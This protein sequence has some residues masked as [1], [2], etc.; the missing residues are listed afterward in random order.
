MKHV[1]DGTSNTM[2]VGEAFHDFEAVEQSGGRPESGLGNR[3][4]HWY[5]GSDDIDTG[6]GSDP[7]KDSDQELAFPSTCRT[8][9]PIS[10]RR[11]QDLPNVRSCSFPLAAFTLAA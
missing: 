8:S 2:F 5:F 11:S 1:I 4:D 3:Q 10:L 7:W 6:D 9:V